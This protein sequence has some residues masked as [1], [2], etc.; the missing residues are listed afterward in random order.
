MFD[1]HIDTIDRLVETSKNL[2][3]VNNNHQQ[4][5]KS[6]NIHYFLF[7][8]VISIKSRFLLIHSIRL[9]KLLIKYSCQNNKQEEE[10]ST[11]RKN[12]KTRKTSSIEEIY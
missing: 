11:K 5:N 1:F 9:D 7:N 10:I 3:K 6:K 4:K 12:K 8:E 2:L